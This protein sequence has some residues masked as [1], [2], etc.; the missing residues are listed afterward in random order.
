MVFAA[1]KKF[2]VGKRI[3]AGKVLISVDGLHLTFVAGKKLIFV[4]EIHLTFVDGEEFAVVERLAA[5]EV[6]AA[7]A[8]G[9]EAGYFQFFSQQDF[10]LVE[11]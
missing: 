1:G 7:D 3:V 10:H 2:S 4:D 11:S 5:G 8:F 6:F 9:I